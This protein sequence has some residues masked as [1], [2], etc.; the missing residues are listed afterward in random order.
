MEQQAPL[1]QP[2]EGARAAEDI[3]YLNGSN[4]DASRSASLEAASSAAPAA[5]GS[6]AASA[7]AA[8]AASGVEPIDLDDAD[9]DELMHDMRQEHPP[10]SSPLTLDSSGSEHSDD[11]EL[12]ILAVRR[13]LHIPLHPHRHPHHHHQPRRRVVHSPINLLDD[14]DDE[15]QGAASSAAAAAAASPA[16]SASPCPDG[17]EEDED[18]DVC[19]ICLCAPTVLS[20]PGACS[21]PYCWQCLEQWTRI[22]LS[23]IYK[24]LEEQQVQAVLQGF[25][26]A[27]SGSKK[28]H[29]SCPQCKRDY[30]VVR[31][32]PS[33][34]SAAA[35]LAA[36][37]SAETI[38]IQDILPPPNTSVQQPTLS[39]QN[40]AYVGNEHFRLAG[41]AALN[42]A[43][44]TAPSLRR[45]LLSNLLHQH[46]RVNAL[47]ASHAPYRDNL[48]RVRAD[49]IAQVISTRDAWLRRQG[50]AQR[51]EV[52]R[53]QRQEQ[54]AMEYGGP[55]GDPVPLNDQSVQQVLLARMS[56]FNS[57]GV[58]AL[59]FGHEPAPPANPILQLYREARYKGGITHYLGRMRLW[60]DL[61]VQF[62]PAQPDVIWALRFNE[63][64]L[65]RRP[66]AEQQPRPAVPPAFAAQAS[67]AAAAAGDASASSAPSGPAAAAPL[68]TLVE[69]LNIELTSLLSVRQQQS[70]TP[71]QHEHFLV[72]LVMSYLELLLDKLMAEEKAYE[73]EKQ[74]RAASTALQQQRKRKREAAAAAAAAAQ[75]SSA[76]ATLEVD[77]EDAAPV[78]PPLSSSFVPSLRSNSSSLH[79]IPSGA[80]MSL[81]TDPSAAAAR[82]APAAAAAAAAATAPV[83][84][85]SAAARRSSPAAE[86]ISLDDD[87]DEVAP[88]GAAAA[89]AVID[90]ETAALIESSSSSLSSSASSVQMGGHMHTLFAFSAPLSSSVDFLF[91][92]LEEFLRGFTGVFVHRLLLFIL[93]RAYSRP[94]AGPAPGD[95]REVLSAEA[96]AAREQREHSLRDAL[97]TARDQW[98]ASRASEAN[99]SVLPN[100]PAFTRE[101]E[102]RLRREKREEERAQRRAAMREA[103]GVEQSPSAGAAAEGERK[104]NRESRRRA[105]P[106]TGFMASVF[107]DAAP[108]AAAFSGGAAAASSSHRPRRSR[109]SASSSPDPSSQAAAAAAN[110]DVPAAAAATGAAASS[111]WRDPAMAST[112]R[113]FLDSEAAL[114][115]GMTSSKRPRTART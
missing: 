40:P 101:M 45:E 74:N 36:P 94:G 82:T 107:G 39:I 2:L 83:A 99:A 73:R 64:G 115:S 77:D 72:N 87:E 14:D 112:E 23:A 42:F 95:P 67:A 114:L 33:A 17:D 1:D 20:I 98:R 30:A 13:A 84:G 21:H 11:D 100:Q 53:L 35:A 34:T 63:V 108:A 104:E 88:R 50:A 76:P 4:G 68:S 102:R 54:L 103:A 111:Q 109:A 8:A 61:R 24:T 22:Q 81:D 19:A 51:V 52:S 58:L 106:S 71:E 32:F 113:R 47:L 5:A 27:G 38:P 55:G 49:L 75:S 96:L 44:R 26:P 78:V 60:S 70:A 12:T 57:A 9:I 37:A 48:A 31:R 56:P 80:P 79:P 62:I 25:V 105:S 92:K 46:P 3:P 18:G 43:M 97:Q 93:S 29:P 110:D 66:F 16:A 85:P 86:I 15:V 65:G 41:E 91:A 69:W 28:T 89:G 90:P 10:P 59:A 6:A 7:A